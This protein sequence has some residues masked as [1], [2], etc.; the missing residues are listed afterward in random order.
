M[1]RLKKMQKLILANWKSNKSVEQAET[2]FAELERIGVGVGESFTIAVAPPFPLLPVVS[3]GAS[4]L[5]WKVAV[6]DLSSFPAGSYT[7]AVSAANLKGFSVAYAILGHSERRRYFHETPEDVARK[8]DQAVE[9]GIQPVV[10][11]DESNVEAQAATLTQA[12]AERCIVAYEP[13]GAIGTGDNV[14]V[15]QVKEF[16]ARVEQLFGSVPLLYGGSVDE[17][18]IAEY[19]LVTDGVLLGGAS[20][21]ADQFARVLQ[22]AQGAS[23]AE[24]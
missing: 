13:S 19:L 21:E 18:N 10:C 17:Q 7:G 12:S 2:W 15:A 4:A 9:A 5:G 6:Q 20:L 23:R 22:S 3:E 16:R 1:I 8:V 11:V 24:V 14:S